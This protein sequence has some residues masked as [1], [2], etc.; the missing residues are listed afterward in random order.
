MTLLVSERKAARLAGQISPI[1]MRRFM[2]NY[3][4]I[5]KADHKSG[6]WKRAVRGFWSDKRKAKKIILS[7][8]FSI[9]AADSLIIFFSPSS[10][11]LILFFFIVS[12]YL[13]LIIII[14]F[15]QHFDCAA[16]VAHRFCQ[17]I[18]CYFIFL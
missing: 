18:T 2:G 3:P 11:N 5:K 16:K 9:L 15:T 17:I 8:S 13:S 14:Y 7:I 10:V 6:L 4:V 12:L 1:E